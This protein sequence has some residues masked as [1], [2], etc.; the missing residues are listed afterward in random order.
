MKNSVIHSVCGAVSVAAICA[1]IVFRPAQPVVHVVERP[2]T[3]VPASVPPAPLPPPAPTPPAQPAAPEL[4]RVLLDDRF[5]GENEGVPT[6]M[7]DRFDHW[8]VEGGTVDLV[9]EG[10]DWDF[11]PGNGLY[12]DLDGDRPNG[13]DFEP[14]ALVSRRAF[15]L[16]PGTY[17]LGFRL[18]GSH[19]G[20][21]NTT[22]VSFGDVFRE[23]ITLPSDA[24]FERFSRTIRVRRAT[25]ARLRFE[26]EGADGYGLL[27]DGVRVTRA[28]R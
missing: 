28:A 12:V 15:S 8:T 4:S 24:S 23:E 20:D 18:A 21:V 25:Q 27:I 14:G 2:V 1:A 9:G 13:I 22:V 16:E 10:S 17:L 5:D 26:N 7:Y 11:Q 19:R 3:V 6:L